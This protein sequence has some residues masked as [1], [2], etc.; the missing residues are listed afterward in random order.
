MHALSC[1]GDYFR[2]FEWNN[3]NTTS[4]LGL[5]VAL[6]LARSTSMHILTFELSQPWLPPAQV[7]ALSC[8]YMNIQLETPWPP[9]D[10]TGTLDCQDHDW[11]SVVKLELHFMSK[12]TVVQWPHQP[13]ALQH[14][15]YLLVLI[16][17]NLSCL[18]ITF[19]SMQRSMVRTLHSD[20]LM[21]GST[22]SMLLWVPMLQTRSLPLLH[23]PRLLPGANSSGVRR[24]TASSP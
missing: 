21:Q 9:L 17:W 18:E 24:L 23:R 7:Q 10:W 19:L 22:I 20:V 15:L 3:S 5:Y 16:L 12:V 6:I 13:S 2:V 1:E 14:E 11:V 4:H 8:H